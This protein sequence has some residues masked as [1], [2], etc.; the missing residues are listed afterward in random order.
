MTFFRNE[1]FMSW[2]GMVTIDWRAEEPRWTDRKFTQLFDEQ[3]RLVFD[4]YQS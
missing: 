2:T 3:G 1:I 4:K